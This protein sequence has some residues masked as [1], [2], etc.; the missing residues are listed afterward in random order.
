MT[1]LLL[2]LVSIACFVTALYHSFRGG[3]EAEVKWFGWMI[4]GFVIGTQ[5][6]VLKLEE[7]VTSLMP[8]TI[9]ETNTEEEKQ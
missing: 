9:Q 2:A 4:L 5:A 3:F 8:E 6:H 7:D 1:I